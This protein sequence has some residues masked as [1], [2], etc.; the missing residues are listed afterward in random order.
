MLSLAELHTN[1]QALATNVANYLGVLPM[2][3]IES[4]FEVFTDLIATVNGCWS[5][6]CAYLE[7]VMLEVFF[8]NDFQDSQAY[9]ARNRIPSECVEVFHVLE[10][11]RNLLCGYHCGKWE[12]ISDC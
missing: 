9:N 12:S 1:E 6:V 2:D 11:R 10:C 5:G 3:G 8:L 7:C 4:T